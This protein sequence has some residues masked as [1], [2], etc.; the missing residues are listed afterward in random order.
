LE[1]CQDGRFEHALLA[2]RQRLHLGFGILCDRDLK[3]HRSLLPL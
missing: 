2:G 3:R 1:P